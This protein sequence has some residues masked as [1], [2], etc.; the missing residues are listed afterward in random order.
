MRR[1]HRRR[2][3]R[4]D[5][6]EQR[7]PA[8]SAKL[9]SASASSTTPPRSPAPPATCSRIA[10]PTPPPGP[11]TTALCR[12]S[13][14]KAASSVGAVD[15]PHHHRQAGRGIDRQRLARARD[16]HQPGPGPQRAARRQPRRAR[17]RQ[18]ARHHHGMAA[19]IFVAVGL[20]HRKPRAPQRRFV[21]EGVRLD[22]RRAR[23]P[24]CRYRRPRPARN[25]AGPAAAD[26]RACG[27]RRSRC[28]WP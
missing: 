7:L 9:V 3:A 15:R 22:R 25:A 5:R 28:G 18:T 20:R 24:E 4:G 6:R 23:L 2:L 27:G 14:R 10:S 16:R 26:G 21:G 17:A 1:Q 11:S 8:R 13:A 12:L 19:G